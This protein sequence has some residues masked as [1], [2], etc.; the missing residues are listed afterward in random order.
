MK[1]V[2]LGRL[3]VG[4]MVAALLVGQLPVGAQGGVPPAGAQG[5]TPPALQPLPPVANGDS[6]FGA[7]QAIFAP[8][9]A[10]NAGVK[11]QRLIFPWDQI[12]PNNAGEF[13][14]GYFSDAEI[15]AQRALGFDIVGVTLYTPR[16]AARAQ[17]YGGRS[18]PANLQLSIDDP[19]NYWAAY[20]KRL[21]SHYRGRIDTWVFYN[22]PDM[23]HDP[24]D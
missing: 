2:A 24:D 1:R 12:Q 5:G 6:W 20:V 4:A 15:D 23:Y 19:Q 17:R 11:W 9:A 7:V 22:E 18:V 10:L 3:L 14:Q 13:G 8:Q 16:W 21:V